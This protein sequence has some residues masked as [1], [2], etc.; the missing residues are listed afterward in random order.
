M[1]KIDYKMMREHCD[2]KWARMYMYRKWRNLRLMKRANKALSK[3]CIGEY[4]KIMRGH[5]D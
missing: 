4:H 5:N 1:P 2:T 3:I